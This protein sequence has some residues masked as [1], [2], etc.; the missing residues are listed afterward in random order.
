MPRIPDNEIER[1]KN[2][3]S[4]EC[5]VRLSAVLFRLPPQR[6][7]LPINR[8][9]ISLSS[10]L[11]RIRFVLAYFRHPGCISTLFLLAA[12]RIAERYPG[13]SFFVRPLVRFN[14]CAS[15]HRRR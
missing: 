6:I 5:P 9:V 15:L 8:P 13:Q 10:P 4:V 1:L 14:R 2:E 12:Q 11:H 3:V 7:S